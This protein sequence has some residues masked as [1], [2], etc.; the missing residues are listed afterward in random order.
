[1]S[2]SQHGR[3]IVA[4]ADLVGND[5]YAAT[6]VANVLAYAGVSRKA[7]YQ[8]FANKQEC[9]LAAYDAIAAEG[10]REVSRAYESASNPVDGAQ[11]AIAKVFER[12]IG[13]PGNVRL[14][15]VEAGVV[16]QAGI[17]R[18]ERL[19]SEYEGPAARHARAAAGARHAS[20]TLCSG[21]SSAV[22]TGYSTHTCAAAG[23]SSC[24][25]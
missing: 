5:G 11:L 14:A 1:M 18:R 3:L 8:H 24:A 6:T 22:S 20:P 19:M 4:M 15:L 12:A 25:S 17:E 2:A 23:W 10:R 7:F 21:G 13:N 9:F 16:G